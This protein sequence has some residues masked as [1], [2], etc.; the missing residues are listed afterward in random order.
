MGNRRKAL[1]I[2]LSLTLAFSVVS[3]QESQHITKLSLGPFESVGI[4]TLLDEVPLGSKST[5][6]PAY[7]VGIL[8]VYS[9]NSNSKSHLWADNL[10]IVMG[11]AYESR[12]MKFHPEGAPDYN[13]TI[14]LNYLMIQPSV[15]LPVSV[16]GIIAGVNIG[17]PISGYQKVEPSGF[18]I[19]SESSP[20][21]IGSIENGS[22]P[23]NHL[24]NIFD[25]RLG[26][27]F[28]MTGNNNSQFGIYFQGSYSLSSALPPNSFFVDG[29]ISTSLDM[30]KTRI[31][32]IQIGF[33]YLF[34]L[35][36]KEVDLT[37]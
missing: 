30:G 29:Q 10:F 4:S 17:I 11:A 18:I 25:I 3:A 22:I 15:I 33:I 36:K 26:F 19:T 1:T 12:A 7:A 35:W 2:F 5:F 13:Q 21:P 16:L 9:L 31:S 8:A 6:S 20:D 27:E 34:P 14:R 37:Q 23:R 32:T 24:N 28:G